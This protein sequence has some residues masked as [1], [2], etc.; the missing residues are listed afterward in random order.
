MI[1]GLTWV[2]T[3]TWLILFA[4]LFAFSYYFYVSEEV[5]PCIRLAI[6][7]QSVVIAGKTHA[8]YTFF[9][10]NT[11]LPMIAV[12]FISIGGI[13]LLVANQKAYSKVENQK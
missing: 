13:I 9:H 8:D 1:P 7:G 4:S 6:L 12:I 10:S 2:Q 5:S 3:S 11:A